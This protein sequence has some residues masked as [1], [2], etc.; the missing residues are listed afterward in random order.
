MQETWKKK[1]R[2]IGEL[3]LPLLL[4]YYKALDKVTPSITIWPMGSL[5][6]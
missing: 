5:L 1:K 4:S 6:G 2:K 3:H